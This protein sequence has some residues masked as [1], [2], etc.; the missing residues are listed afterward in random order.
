MPWSYQ[1]C[2]P[3]SVMCPY[4]LPAGNLPRILLIYLPSLYSLGMV[5]IVAWLLVVAL[6]IAFLVYYRI[7]GAKFLKSVIITLSILACI[8]GVSGLVFVTISWHD[9]IPNI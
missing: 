4:R 8:W 5:A 1:L 3:I 2:P 6:P 7:R 9:N